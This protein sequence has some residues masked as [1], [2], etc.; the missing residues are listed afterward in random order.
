[1]ENYSYDNNTELKGLLLLLLLLLKAS[2][3]FMERGSFQ[4]TSLMLL[5]SQ[6]SHLQSLPPGSYFSSGD[7]PFVRVGQA[8]SHS[9]LLR[10]ASRLL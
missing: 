10:H 1:M 6:S 9:R 3:P 7:L 8:S 5:S 2:Y 4:E